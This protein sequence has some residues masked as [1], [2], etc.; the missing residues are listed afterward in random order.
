[1]ITSSAGSWTP[2]A[3]PTA[4]RRGRST[5]PSAKASDGQAPRWPGVAVDAGPPGPGDQ[6][7]GRRLK[8]QGGTATVRSRPFREQERTSGMRELNLT[9]DFACCACDKPVRVTVQCRGDSQAPERQGPGGAR[10]GAEAPLG[11]VNVPCPT[12]GQINRLAFD[13]DGCVRSVRPF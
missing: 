6:A 4:S 11:A 13:P 8:D 12:C 5:A 9:L 1:A 7:R 2:R 3:S 10:A